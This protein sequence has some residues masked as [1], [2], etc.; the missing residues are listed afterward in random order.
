MNI[1]TQLS[2]VFAE[3]GIVPGFMDAT[4]ESLP[5]EIK[6]ELILGAFDQTKDRFSDI[7]RAQLTSNPGSCKRLTNCKQD[8]VEF[9]LRWCKQMYKYSEQEVCLANKDYTTDGSGPARCAGLRKTTAYDDCL[10]SAYADVCGNKFY[11][12]DIENC[13]IQADMGLIEGV[14]GNQCAS[15]KDALGNSESEYSRCA[16]PY[17]EQYPD[18]QGY[19]TVS[20]YDSCMK[21]AYAKAEGIC[22]E[23]ACFIASTDGRQVPIRP[24]NENLEDSVTSSSIP[25]GNGP[26]IMEALQAAG[27]DACY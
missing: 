1:S 17:L 20:E 4:F 14:A 11:T 24:R 23:V 18:C 16:K 21:D 7:Y 26:A 25:Y 22:M 13:R 10:A 15:S 8:T 6:Y 3:Y 5:R 27:Y 19:S 9:E 12:A 2:S